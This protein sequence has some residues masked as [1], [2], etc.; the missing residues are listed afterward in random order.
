[1]TAKR[2]AAIKRWQQAGAKAK[3]KGSSRA[4]LRF[5]FHDKQ[6]REVAALKKLRAAAKARKVKHKGWS[7][8][9]SPSLK[10]ANSKL[11][12]NL[13]SKRRK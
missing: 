10:A 2:K 8:S 6:D 1:M 7:A 12:A 4:E 11:R 13:F 3:K 9:V 5:G